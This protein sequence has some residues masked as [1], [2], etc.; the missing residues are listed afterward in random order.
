M[1]RIDEKVLVI[2]SYPYRVPDL[3]QVYSP[4]KLIRGIRHGRVKELKKISKNDHHTWCPNR[5][6]KMKCH[7][8]TRRFW[9]L[10]VILIGY[11]TYTKYILHINWY[12][13]Y[14][15]TESRNWRK[16]PK[17]TITHDVLIKYLIWFHQIKNNL[18]EKGRQLTAMSVKNQKQHIKE[19]CPLLSRLLQTRQ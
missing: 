4:N 3:Y 14:A 6:L 18:S 9:W 2:E 5:I 17:M 16:Y 10:K 12:A 8:S 1:P 11:L 19:N 15:T 7:V 13:G